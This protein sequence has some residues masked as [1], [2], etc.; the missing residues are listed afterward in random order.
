MQPDSHAVPPAPLKPRYPW[1]SR[2]TVVFALL[3]A[4]AVVAAI[5]ALPLVAPLSWS[6]LDHYECGPGATVATRELWTPVVMIN[7]PYGGFGNGTGSFGKG[8]SWSTTVSNGNSVG[9]FVSEEWSISRAVR[10]LVAGPGANAI[11]CTGFLATG[12]PLGNYTGEALQT[13]NATSNAAE[14]TSISY[15]NYDSVVFHNSYVETDRSF[16]SCSG[17]EVVLGV[18][19][20]RIAVGVPFTLDG[21]S[22][23]ASGTLEGAFNYTYSFPG[24]FGT[25]SIDDL[26]AG[27]NA[28]GGG[29]AFS[30]TPCL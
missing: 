16:S 30:F 9:W 4:A 8:W 20:S 23:T 18:T 2:R 19:A 21:S 15:A 11:V 3:A 24:H 28:P 25:W 6:P 29:W 7:A 10:V 22:Y 26:N 1:P 17:G 13:G 5:T 14:N 27:T 12:R